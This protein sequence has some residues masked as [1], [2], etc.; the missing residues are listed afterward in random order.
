MDRGALLGLIGGIAVFIII[1][2]IIIN[3]HSSF[4]QKLIDQV[5]AGVPSQQLIPQIDEETENMEETAKARVMAIVMDKKYWGNGD[6]AVPKEYEAYTTGYEFEMRLIREYDSARIKYA[7]REITKREFLN[8]I[9]GPK[10]FYSIYNNF[11]VLNYNY[12]TLKPYGY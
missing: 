8:I 11:R 3:N 7:N 2:I 6:L 1:L 9:K 12:R 4:D 5:E 10:E